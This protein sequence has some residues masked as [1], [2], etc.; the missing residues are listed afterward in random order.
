MSRE[1]A[2]PSLDRGRG[3]VGDRG[4]RVSAMVRSH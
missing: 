2:V 3:R 1:I 4:F